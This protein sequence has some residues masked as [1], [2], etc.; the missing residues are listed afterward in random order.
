MRC[1]V[2]RR[3]I[4]L[5][6]LSCRLGALPGGG[7]FEQHAVRINARLLVERDELAALFHRG[8]RV[9]GEP[10]VNLGGHASRHNL[11]NLHA[12]VDKELVDGQLQLGRGRAAL[13]ARIGHRLVHCRP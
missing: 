6:Q 5:F 8:L 2:E 3:S 4:T 1:N 13:G 11:E 9:K 12:K 7:D 10:C